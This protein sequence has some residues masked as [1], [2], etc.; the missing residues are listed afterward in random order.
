[1]YIAYAMIVN[2][3]VHSYKFPLRLECSLFLIFLFNTIKV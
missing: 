1:M 3:G 2:V